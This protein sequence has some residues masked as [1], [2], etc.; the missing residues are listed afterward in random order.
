MC[1]CET[2]KFCGCDEKKKIDWTKPIQL[3][4]YYGIRPATV[5]DNNYKDTN[6]PGRLVKFDCSNGT[7]GLFL[8]D[9][10]GKLI[11]KMGNAGIQ[12]FVVENVP[13][14]KRFNVYY[15]GGLT[16]TYPENATYVPESIKR[17][18]FKTV[19]FEE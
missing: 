15:N 18:P 16:W 1:K 11:S 12:E 17:Y 6:K 3:R 9:D 5:I 7:H 19:E 8:Y 13:N 14:K 2:K 4:R 10:S